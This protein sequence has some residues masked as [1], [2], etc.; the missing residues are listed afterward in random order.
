[1][2]P[3]NLILLLVTISSSSG[4]FHK[5]FQSLQAKGRALK[6]STS[7]TTTKECDYEVPERVCREKEVC[8]TKWSE[9]C[10]QVLVETCKNVDEDVCKQVWSKRCSKS[11]QK[12]CKPVDIVDCHQENICREKEVCETKRSEECEQVLVETCKDVDQEVCK[13][14]WSKKCSKSPQ[15]KCK[16]V[17][18]VDCHQENI[19]T[20]ETRVVWKPC[21]HT[22]SYHA[23]ECD[24]EVNFLK[25]IV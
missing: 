7:T 24:Y 4:L 5:L 18:I 1:M 12:K 9:E 3:S 15:K 10:E 13:Q 23:Q 17:D 20:T 21:A 2:R 16:P 25:E 8:E 22:S 6:G 11:P 14:V 19:C